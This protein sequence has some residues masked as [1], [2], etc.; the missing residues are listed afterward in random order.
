MGLCENKY[1]N[2]VMKLTTSA[3]GTVK[4]G[5]E[6]KSVKVGLENKSVKV[7]LDNKSA[8]VGLENNLA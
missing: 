5:L 2:N 7:S 6:N 1:M 3:G 4:F 8:K